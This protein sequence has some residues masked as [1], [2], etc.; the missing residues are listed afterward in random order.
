MARILE[1]TLNGR[2]KVDAVPDNLVL[3]DYLREV[4][5]LH[6][7]KTGCNGGECGACTVL[8]DGVQIH[9]KENRHQPIRGEIEASFRAATLATIPQLRAFAFLLSR[10]IDRADDLVQKTLP[11][12]FI[13][14]RRF[15]PG[16]NLQAWLITILRNAL[17][18]EERSRRR[19]LE[20][21]DRIYAE[22]LVVP[23][24]QA[25]RPE[26]EEFSGK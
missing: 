16:S 8:V 22:T 15:E 9:R 5:G 23:A 18:S 1:F 21:G 10:N 26:R 11:R 19:E 7:T 3:L 17:Y 25:S 20:D 12:A 2:P 13:N 14:R 24:E 4:V 6:G